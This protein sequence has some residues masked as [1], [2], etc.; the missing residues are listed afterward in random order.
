AGQQLPQD[1]APDIASLLQPE[2]PASS[3]CAHQER[4]AT[5]YGLAPTVNARHCDV[6]RLIAAP[7]RKEQI[8]SDA[9]GC[10]G[11]KMYRCQCGMC[12]NGKSVITAQN[13]IVSRS[14]MTA[15]AHA[16]DDTV[17]DDVV[18]SNEQFARTIVHG[19]H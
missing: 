2:V 4:K 19:E 17:S 1:A 7:L 12:V 10:A 18:K 8:D 16:I 13:A 14:M 11:V 5:L 15:G 9:S 3:T 6:L